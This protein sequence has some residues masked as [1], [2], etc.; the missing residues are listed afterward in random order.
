MSKIE[1]VS[2]DVSYGFGAVADVL[3]LAITE[4]LVSFTTDT[5]QIYVDME[6]QRF[7]Y[8][9]IIMV[10]T[11]REMMELETFAQGKLYFAEDTRCL[12]MNEDGVWVKVFETTEG[13]I[14]S[15]PTYLSV[16]YVDVLPAT[17]SAKEIYLLD[18]N[19]YG[20]GVPKQVWLYNETAGSFFRVIPTKEEFIV[21][22]DEQ[23][24]TLE[25]E[26]NVLAITLK[27][28]LGGETSEDPDIS[29][30]LAELLSNYPLKDTVYTKTE[31]DAKIDSA[32]DTMN[33]TI[34]NVQEDYKKSKFSTGEYTKV[35]G[36]ITLSDNFS[37]Y[38]APSTNIIT[39]NTMNLTQY[40]NTEIKFTLIITGCNTVSPV[41]NANIKWLENVAPNYN[42]FDNVMM[43]LRSY[44]NGVTWLGIYQ[45]GWNDVFLPE[46]AESD[47]GS[48]SSGDG[49]G[50]GGGGWTG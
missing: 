20:S 37:T 35:S 11:E 7:C 14:G 45:G 32:V 15:L 4:G 2:T 38:I 48:E 18:Y 30:V 16:S 43:E 26:L 8:D 24:Q 6:G 25:Q 36:D 12:Y 17:G 42:D 28:A 5:N 50:G 29:E 46:E 19:D 31:T 9:S 22:I 49:T 3:N 27:A 41:V 44:N 13:I 40:T 10:A 1:R 39:F 23:L 47:S 21:V 34:A 33:N